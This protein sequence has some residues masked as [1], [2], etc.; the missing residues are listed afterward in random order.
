MINS[1]SLWLC[2]TIAIVLIICGCFALW[3]ALLAKEDLSKDMLRKASMVAESINI[4]RIKALTGDKSDLKNPQYLR[5]KEQLILLRNLY[6]DCRFLYLM[7]RRD[8]GKIFFFMDSEPTGSKDY[9]TPG[10]IYDEVPEGCLRVFNTRNGEVEDS[11]S[12]RWG[13]RVSAFVPIHDPKTAIHILSTRNEAQNMVKKAVEFYRKN[14]KELLLKEINNSNGQFRVGD[15]YAFAYDS[16]MTMMA[17]PVKPQLVGKNLLNKKDWAGGQYFR[18]DIQDLALSK[19]S[20]WIDYEYEN[21]VNKQREPKSTYIQ[22]VDDLIICAGAYRGTGAIV[23]VLGVDIDSIK[24]NMM[25]FRPTIPVLLF[26]VALIIVIVIGWRLFFI[27]ANINGIPPLWMR[28]LEPC[29]AAIVGIIV[30]IFATWIFYIHN[31]E[32]RKEAFIQLA[33]NR[34]KAIAEKMYKIRDTELEGLAHLYE[35]VDYISSKKFLEFTDYLTI[36][37]SVHWS[38]TPIV[39]LEDKVKFEEVT[40]LEGYRD[41]EIWQQNRQGDRIPVLKRE[42]Y[43]PLLHTTEVKGKKTEFIG[44]DLGSE[45][46]RYAALQEAAKTGLTTCTEPITLV[47]EN[48]NQ[49]AI[50]IYRPVF[51]NRNLNLININGSDV[52][53]LTRNN[54]KHLRG[55][56]VAALR[57]GNLLRTTAMDNSLF[58]K[59]SLLK[60]GEIQHIEDGWTQDNIP[61]PLGLEMTFPIV[62]FGKV[63]ALTVYSSDEFMTLYPKWYAILAAIAGIVITIA[64]VFVILI[65]I[66]SREKLETLVLKRTVKLNESESMQRILLDNLPVGVVILNPENHT[67][68][69]I[70]HYVANM[71]GNSA[72]H[73]VGR[74]CNSIICPAKEFY[75]PVQNPDRE[76]YNAEQEMLRYDGSVITILKTVQWIEINGKRKILECFVDISDRKVAEESLLETNK[77]LEEAINRANKM[78]VEAQMA[79]IAKS[80][81]LANM[82]HEIRTPMNGVIGM[83]GLLLDTEL[84]YEQRRYAEIVRSSAESLL[85]IIND[86]LDFSKIEAKKLDLEMFDFD[87]LSLLEDFS[88]I[89]AIRANEKGLKFFC[90]V[91]SDVPNR[92]CGDPGRVRQILTN[93]TGNAIKFTDQ[94]EVLIHVSL[95]REEPFTNSQSQSRSSLIEEK[96]VMLR[97]SVS[98]TGI[99]I[100]EDKLS[101]VFEKFSQVDSSTTRKYGGTGLGLAISKQLAELMGGAIGAKSEEGKGSKFWFTAC[102]IK[103]IEDR[104]SSIKEL[105]LDKQDKIEIDVKENSFADR[106]ARILLVEDNITNQKVEL[107]I[108]KKLGLAADAVANGAEAVK[109]IETL[110]YDLVFMDI[111]MPVMDGF[112]ATRQIRNLEEQRQEDLALDGLEDEYFQIENRSIPIIAMTAHAMRGDREKCLQAGMN[113]YISKPVSPD[114]IASILERWLPKKTVI[115]RNMLKNQQ[116]QIQNQSKNKIDEEQ[117]SSFSNYYKLEIDKNKIPIFDKAGFMERIMDDEELAVTLLDVFIEDIPEQI[118]LLKEY[119]NSAD[120]EKIERQAHSIKGACVNIGGEV[121]RLVA[122]NMEKAAKDG[123]MDIVKELMVELESQ[124]EQ[125][126]KA[127]LY[128][129]RAI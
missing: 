65:S 41:F 123:N 60:D 14:G 97:F 79:D 103:Q 26:T 78:A 7:G 67:I 105:S 58:M 52:S 101:M 109:S 104:V 46:I 17:H 2:S 71:F 102:F 8:D 87:L 55:F 31:I 15:L 62:A 4:D 108:L 100:P 16:N 121:M 86:I 59:I 91:D 56:V 83:A 94:G 29:L 85:S 45:P 129:K 25:I 37:P 28:F 32:H 92:L 19:G 80:E 18:N 30:T 112:E 126:K 33:S 10:Q 54:T 63:F 90:N 12:D 82:S 1:K 107:A 125:L 47:Y 99:G 66:R 117:N 106:D 64:I 120:N 57:M 116:I 11:Y 42:L 36:N 40:R 48:N 13:D 50:L 111:Q 124:F 70:N 122:Y 20:G 24:L 69:R 95:D 72:E 113:D 110:P 81:F 39:A 84:N 74:R 88:A 44:Y 128:S 61:P 38:W 6:D 68:E 75:C 23:A 53:G 27:R 115:K 93:L 76:F 77:Q 9:S 73:L 34:V 127:I 114:A 96:S 43:Y 5:L 119:V 98:D 89:F 21:P 35:G 3:A 51:I 22:R 49:K 118:D